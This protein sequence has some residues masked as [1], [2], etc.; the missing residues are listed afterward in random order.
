MSVSV[1]LKRKLSALGHGLKPV[2]S[3]AE[4]GVS[5]GVI[6]E[7]N[8]ALLDHELIKIRFS[9]SDRNDKKLLIQK[10]LDQTHAELIQAI[11]HV[12]LIYKPADKPNPRLSNL[13][14]NKSN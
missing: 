14:R 9:V 11:G 13:I 7:T 12:I 10:L 5:E 6:L 1:A 3:V 4:K 2:V 8:R